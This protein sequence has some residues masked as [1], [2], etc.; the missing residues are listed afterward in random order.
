MEQPE[1]TSAEPPVSSGLRLS[2]TGKVQ[3][4]WLASVQ[5]SGGLTA[6]KKGVRKGGSGW[7]F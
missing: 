3:W 7:H 4:D 1:K 6:L 5:Y 2:K